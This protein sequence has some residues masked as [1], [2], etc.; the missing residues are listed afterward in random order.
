MLMSNSNIPASEL[1]WIEQVRQLMTDLA[2][3]SLADIPQLPPS[4]SDRVRPLLER[5]KV[6]QKEAVLTP[7]QREWVDRVRQLLLELFAQMHSDRPHLPENLDRR[8]L[9][10]AETARTLQETAS[11]V[12]S[13]ELPVPTAIGI[14][15]EPE[16]RA[17]TIDPF[18]AFRKQ[19]RVERAN[20]ANGNAPEWQQLMNL[21]DVAEGLYRRVKG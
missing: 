13:Q 3:Y 12:P 21:L 1:E 4:V 11:T 9:A 7:S 20:S 15:S 17:Q 5:A 6:M 10:L 16:V 18:E 2:R 14:E 19:V 8:A